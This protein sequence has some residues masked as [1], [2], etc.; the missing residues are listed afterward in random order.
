MDKL[1]AYSNKRIATTDTSFLRF[2]HDVVDWN[3]RLIAITGARGVG[4]TTF[5]LQHIKLN[6]FNRPEEVIFV[7][8]DDLHF[9][10]S[11]LIDFADEFVKRGGKYLFIDEIHKYKG[12]STEIKNIY[13][14]FNE[15][16][17]VITGSSALDIFK[18]GADLSRRTVSYKMPGLSFREY[19][20]LSEG[21]ETQI[22]SLE[23]IMYRHVQIS[24][25]IAR[26][27]K[28]IK[29]FKEYLHYGYYPFFKENTESFPLKLKQAVNQVIETDLPA[30]V[31]VDYNSVFNLRKLLSI[32]TEIVPFKPNITKLSQQVTVSRETLVRYLYHLSNADLLL[33]LQSSTKGISRMN[34]PEK[35][36]LHNPN[37]M[38]ALAEQEV[39]VGTLRELF[40]YN[41]LQYGHKIAASVT[42]DFIVDSKYTFE[43][44]GKNKN[45]E[46]IKT[47]KDA[48]VASDDIETGS[49]N[50][51]PLW[52]FGMMY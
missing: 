22:F 16:N 42:G 24:T 5:L 17:I 31:H 19:M 29:L 51:I 7:N 27:I 39:N 45:S 9:A 33:L 47:L 52:L 21:F 41:Q 10:K 34:K 23:D 49:G 1:K 12:W 26:K 14:Y 48:F 4:K 6:L 36:Y 8:A 32:I 3:N 11:S 2:M 13:D 28:P 44:G 50:K 46:Q 18:S 25:D 15:L 20:A 38:Y 43:I 37:L 35:I 30:I 40:F